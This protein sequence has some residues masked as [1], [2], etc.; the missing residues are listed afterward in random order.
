MG[1]KVV[2]VV[3]VV[4]MVAVIVGLDL[5][6]LRHHLPER[7]I[8]NVGIVVVFAAFYLRFIGR[9]WRPL[10]KRDSTPSNRYPS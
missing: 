10:T 8:V 3:Y 6:F 2:A 7:L 1:K 9:A 5:T 4:V